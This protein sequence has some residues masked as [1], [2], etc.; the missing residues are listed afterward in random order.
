MT[1][2]KQNSYYKILPDSPSEHDDKLGLFLWIVLGMV[3]GAICTFLLVLTHWVSATGQINIS[4]LVDALSTILVGGILGY[5]FTIKQG[6]ITNGYAE[7]LNKR[8]EVFTL[9]LSKRQED[10]IREMNERQESF[11]REMAER[12]ED[13]ARQMK[14]RE[15]D[16]AQRMSDTQS[17]AEKDRY[18]IT[19]NKSILINYCDKAEA[20]VERVYQMFAEY[21]GDVLIKSAM[22]IA[23]PYLIPEDLKIKI[24]HAHEI[25]FAHI[26]NMRISLIEANFAKAG[27]IEENSDK[28]L[29]QTIARVLLSCGSY[30]RVMVGVPFGEP[31][32]VRE[33]SD[34]FTRC[35]PHHLKLVKDINKLRALITNYEVGRA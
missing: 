16:F 3:F 27:D 9:D 13:F 20:L 14:K 4:D 17:N 11:N 19:S 21:Y 30:S 24:T 7:E 5:I 35:N 31:C 29:P 22:Y 10:F 12:Q 32:T 2:E 6:K 1:G 8:Q 15:E 34:N 28:D 23:E 18:R 26:D 33:L 25:I